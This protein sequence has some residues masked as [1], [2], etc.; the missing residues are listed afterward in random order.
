MVLD[1]ESD[2][3]GCRLILE[4]VQHIE[5]RIGGM[6]LHAFRASKD[7]VDLTAYRL[8]V[9]GETTHRFS[10]DLKAKH[11]EMNWKAIYAL[12]NYAV[13]AYLLLNEEKVWNAAT[14]SLPPLKALC[15]FEL[16][17]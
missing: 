5:R 4:L 8:A 14:F 7:E 6:S 12:R 13:H 1:R 17:A 3:E 16:G 10:S 11:P 15:Q 9:I 2:L